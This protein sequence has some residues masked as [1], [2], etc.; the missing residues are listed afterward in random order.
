MPMK[1]LD[2]QVVEQ[3]LA[4]LELGQPVWLCTVLATFGSAPREPGSMLVASPSGA[5]CGSLS[6]GCVEEDFLQRLAAGE[7]TPASQVVRYGEGG[8]APTVALPCGGSLDV[9]LEHFAANEPA[10]A[11]FVALRRA[12]LGDR[13][14]S[15]HISLGNGEP[16]LDDIRRH[17]PRVS[18][19]QDHICINVGPCTR[20]IVAGVSPVAEY[21]ID[22]AQALGF[23][24][25]VCDPRPEHLAW[26]Q[27]KVPVDKLLE[28]LPAVFIAGGGCHQ[29]TA[30]VALTHDPRL[31]D[32]TLMEA[33]RT[34]AFYIGAMGS[35][36]TSEKRRERL[37]RIGRL[38]PEQL[39]RVHAPI[40][41]NLGS[42]TPAQIAL[43]VMAD[44][45]RQANGV[46]RECL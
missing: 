29:A 12:L 37:A 38:S 40:G 35:A 33:V 36:R 1:P 46:A 21:C 5:F 22:F 15:R 32:L 18:R 39:A 16:S 28:V 20:L 25:I 14:V 41:L 31:D 6:G 11:H 3:A 30:V 27:G 34:Q 42:K 45:V 2:V 8:L 4:W 17:A 9:L 24:V 10:R 44:I 13:P 26:L 43:A 7:F 23:E 19:D